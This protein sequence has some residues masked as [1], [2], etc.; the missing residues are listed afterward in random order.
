MLQEWEETHF[1]LLGR[2]YFPHFEGELRLWLH[3]II[4][5]QSKFSQRRQFDLILRVI[6]WDA[7]SNVWY[8]LWVCVLILYQD[9]QFHSG[10]FCSSWFYI[11]CS[12]RYGKW[13]QRWGCENFIQKDNF[14]KCD[15]YMSLLYFEIT[16]WFL[17]PHK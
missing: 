10:T 1:T 11:L 16:Y 2:Y 7:V 3:F 4:L 17:T 5:T 14:I 9:D 15:S 13:S 8:W 6:L 12:S